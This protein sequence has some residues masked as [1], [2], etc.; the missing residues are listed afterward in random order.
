M[1]SKT[2]LCECN[3]VEH[4]IMFFWFPD[5]M[6]NVYMEIHLPRKTFWERL[7]TGLKH[8]FGYKSRYGDW[9]EV[10]LNKEKIQKFLGELQSVYDQSEKTSTSQ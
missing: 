7:T 6:E 9:D 5:D 3:S 8:I 10:I 1:E 4:Q 2:I